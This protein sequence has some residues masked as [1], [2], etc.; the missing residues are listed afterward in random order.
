MV[1]MSYANDVIQ[2]ATAELGYHAK[3]T[4]DQL[5]DKKANFGTKN[6]T[7]F[8]Q[9]MDTEYP[10]FYGVKRNGQS[11]AGLF[12]DYCMIKAYG[13]QE[14]LRLMYL[15]PGNMGYD[16]DY[17]I[18]VY[19]D[20]GKFGTEPKIGDQV[21]FENHEGHIDHSGLVV[22]VNA[23]SVVVIEGDRGEATTR[24]Y[25][26][27]AKSRIKGYGHPDYSIPPVESIYL[28]FAPKSPLWDFG[29]D[30][31][32]PIR[33]N[34]LDI[35]ALGSITKKTESGSE[36]ESTTTV[37]YNTGNGPVMI[38]ICENGI[39]DEQVAN[40]ESLMNNT[41]SNMGSALSDP[42]AWDK[43][44]RPSLYIKQSEGSSDDD[45]GEVEEVTTL[46]T[47]LS[48]LLT[49]I[50]SGAFGGSDVNYTGSKT[51][52]SDEEKE[53]DFVEWISLSAFGCEIIYVMPA[54]TY[55]VNLMEED[56]KT[57]D[58]IL[59]NK[60]AVS[61]IIGATRLYEK[62]QNLQ[63]DLVCFE[64]ASGLQT[65]HLYNCNL[66][67]NLSSLSGCSGLSSLN[68]GYTN[69]EGE[70]SSLGSTSMKDLRLYNTSISCDVKQ[71]DT[72]QDLET[73]NINNTG[74][75]GDLQHVSSL[76][77]L[78]LFDISDTHI[79]GDIL[80]IADL[81]DLEE[82]WLNQEGI[83]GD[84]KHLA[85]LEKL[86]KL[87][88]SKMNI[89]GDITSLSNLNALTHLELESLNVTG[90]ISKLTNLVGLR[91]LRICSTPIGGVMPNLSVPLSVV[92]DQSGP[93]G[94]ILPKKSEMVQLHLEKTNITGNIKDIPDQ[95][96]ELTLVDSDFTGDIAELQ[97]LS[98]LDNIYLSNVHLTGDIKVF[99]GKADL[100]KLDIHNTQLTG[101][102][103][104][105]SGLQ[106]LEYL[107]LSQTQVGGDIGDL[108][109]LP[110][111]DLFWGYSSNI[112]G[113]I[114]ALAQFTTL[115][116]IRINDTNIYGYYS[117]LK[118]M[119][120]LTSLN[121]FG[122][123]IT[124]DPRS[125]DDLHLAVFC[126][127]DQDSKHIFAGG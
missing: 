73:F 79:Q 62:Y 37:E 106:K 14:A 42:I 108:Y 85:G 86:K 53:I 17:K 23:D 25:Y 94:P 64:G 81:T 104:C 111:L 89:Y 10:S 4:N 87:H 117:S 9:E 24:M 96:T 56:D 34:M 40:I 32:N 54:F 63:C 41:I 77:K 76:K 3:E 8:A 29:E 44:L 110:V 49:E 57:W 101:D 59:F 19:I 82:I 91:V 92:V 90:D 22:K 55:T 93:M 2:I 113:D 127:G 21:F 72:M 84:I 98:K 18:K 45:G 11:W 33:H 46:Q 47:P 61:S 121:V 67:G 60:P 122:S 97:K 13:E 15:E 71:L 116:K 112:T 88:M 58:V 7:K 52:G 27:F 109:D 51:D 115:R 102:I 69:I 16:L 65:L 80:A 28:R 66:V 1:G 68:I 6:F 124:G 39:N 30:P 100:I 119:E 126:Y 99:A 36:G 103:G 31:D 78:K 50:I 123:H 48:T 35:S 43:G 20:H 118:D 114:R 120:N 125:L 95:L 105:L 83:Y 75:Y 74:V 38:V 107:A 12:F 70:L 26:K 5:D